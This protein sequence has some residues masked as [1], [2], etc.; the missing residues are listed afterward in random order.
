MALKGFLCT[1]VGTSKTNCS[2]ICIVC[3]LYIHVYVC[4]NFMFIKYLNPDVYFYSTAIN[5]TSSVSLAQEGAL[6]GMLVADALAMPVHWYYNPQDIHDGYGG[7]LTGYVAA[8][9]RH[10]SSILSLSAVGRIAYYTCI[11]LQ[12]A[13]RLNSKSLC[14][15]LCSC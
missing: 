7:W 10:P 8:N 1:Q 6:W 9:K 13:Y 2:V 14:T 3:W 15:N 5:M 12:T 11:T 4:M